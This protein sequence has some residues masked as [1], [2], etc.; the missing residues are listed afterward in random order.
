MGTIIVSGL[1]IAV[2]VY[3]L[4]II[5]DEFF[6]TSLDQIS[7]KLKLPGNVAGASLMAMG[8]S[9]PELAIALLALFR[10]G[11]HSD[12][13]IGTI[14]GSAVFN[15]LVITGV[16]A[17][18]RPAHVTWRVV[19]RDVVVYVAS[20]ALL[21]IT[22]GNGEI[23]LLESLAFLGLYAIYIVVLF[24]WNAFSPGKEEDIVEVVEAEIESAH[25]SENLYHKITGGISKVLGFFTGDA[26]KSYIRAFLVSI[27][28]IAIISWFLVEYAVVF[29]NAI[30]LPPVIIALTVLAAGT[31][32]PDL[33]SSIIVA[34]QGR[35]EM[36][37]ANAIGSNI[38]DILVGLGLPWLIAATVLGM[39]VVHVGVEDL[40]TSTIVLLSTV[41]LL[42]VFLTTG[43]V[44]SRKEGW[45]LVASYVAFAI[46]I[47]VGESQ[48]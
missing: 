48:Y 6:I 36:A 4:S 43:R 26:K 14:V 1:I 27:M 15:I 25:E 3:L 37:I 28:F 22:F 42:F 39:Q 23:T 20:I 10:G 30:G 21:I 18:A 5:T 40:W 31:S 32:V 41:V 12:V 11:E 19:V 45:V 44:L 13:G 38:F 2:S 46:W 47:L 17:I 29:A 35:G 24:N 8:S 34:R 9:A 16:S 7:N 33:I